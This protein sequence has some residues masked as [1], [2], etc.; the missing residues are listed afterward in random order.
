MRKSLLYLD[1]NPRFE[2][3]F[4]TLAQFEQNNDEFCRVKK[5][6]G[7]ESNVTSLKESDRLNEI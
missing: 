5:V 4:L 6:I 3:R 7:D 2:R 1:H